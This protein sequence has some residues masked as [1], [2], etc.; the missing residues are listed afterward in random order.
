[1]YICI[2]IH[3]FET[4]VFP[5]AES[6]SEEQLLRVL[7]EQLGSVLPLLVS[8]QDAQ[9]GTLDKYICMYTHVYIC[10]CIFVHTYAYTDYSYTYTCTYTYMCIHI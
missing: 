6:A 8:H 3:T 5:S 2:N 1:M 7:E 10:I 4:I 9:P